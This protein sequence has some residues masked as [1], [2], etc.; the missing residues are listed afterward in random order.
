M[1]GIPLSDQ[2]RIAKRRVGQNQRGTLALARDLQPQEIATGRQVPNGVM[3]DKVVALLINHG[4]ER[5]EI[6]LAVRRDKQLPR[7]AQQKAHWLHNLLVNGARQLLHVFALWVAQGSPQGAYGFVNLPRRAK[8]FPLHISLAA[9]NIDDVVP[10]TVGHPFIGQLRIERTVDCELNQGRVVRN[11]STYC[12]E[13]DRLLLGA[14]LRAAAT[15][16]AFDFFPL[17]FESINLFV[18]LGGRI[19]RTV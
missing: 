7:I 13:C 17:L 2:G 12:I 1:R 6:Q 9:N 19:L 11:S 4:G 18:L 15:D 10:L 16:F 5:N 14:K 8:L 3:F